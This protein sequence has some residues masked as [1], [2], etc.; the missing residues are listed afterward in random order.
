MT[1]SPV[2]CIFIQT[3][4]TD[5]VTDPVIAYS[6]FF[7]VTYILNYSSI[8]ASLLSAFSAFTMF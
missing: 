4:P 2:K 8:V 3:K 5:N 6:S 1:F 7:N